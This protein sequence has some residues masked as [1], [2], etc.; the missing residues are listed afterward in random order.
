[1]RWPRAKDVA[2][3]DQVRARVVGMKSARLSVSSVPG[4]NKR[5][6]FSVFES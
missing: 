1:M 2:L 5:Q 6:D 3:P 4:D